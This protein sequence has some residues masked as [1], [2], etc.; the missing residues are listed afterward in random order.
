MLTT[1]NIDVK[2]TNCPEVI[3]DYISETLRRV[4][5]MNSQGYTSGIIELDL[6]KG[7]RVSWS[8]KTSPNEVTT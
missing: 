6:D 2:I 3:E 4:E 8:I 7:T 1:V 5:S